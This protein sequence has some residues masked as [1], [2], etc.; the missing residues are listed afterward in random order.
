MSCKGIGVGECPLHGE[1]LLDTPDSPCPSCEEEE[2]EE[3]D[4]VCL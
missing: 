1:Y 4:E 3:T 2:E